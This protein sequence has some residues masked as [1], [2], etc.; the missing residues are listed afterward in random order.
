MSHL[1][2]LVRLPFRR[3]RFGLVLRQPLHQFFRRRG[4]PRD[5]RLVQARRQLQRRPGTLAGAVAVAVVL[6][7]R[8]RRLARLRH[9]ENAYGEGVFIDGRRGD[10]PGGSRTRAYL[11]EIRFRDAGVR[12]PDPSHGRQCVNGVS[13]TILKHNNDSYERGA[14]YSRCTPD[15]E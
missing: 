6:A 9:L 13:Q 4:Q 12:G 8:G 10:V 5:L 14:I 11:H 1:E 15:A 7:G 2:L 3:L